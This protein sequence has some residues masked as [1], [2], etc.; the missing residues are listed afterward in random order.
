[1]GTGRDRMVRST[2]RGCK[3]GRDFP[4]ADPHMKAHAMT[5]DPGAPGVDI[6][7]ELS[8]T[9][10]PRIQVIRRIGAGGMG[11]VYLGRDPLLH[12]SVAVKVLGADLASDVV[13]HARFMREAE[14]V[15][16][17]NHPNV[18]SV[19]EVGELPSGT[20]YFVME[21]VDGIDMAEVLARDGVLSDA[22][23][24]R[25]IGEVASALAAAHARGLVHRDM[26]P[27]NLMVD[28]ETDRAVVLDFGISAILDRHTRTDHALTAQGTYIG[29]PKYTSPEQAAGE[30]LT[31]KS[32]VYSLGVTAFELLTGRPPFQDDHPM[33]LMA[34]HIK[35]MPP[36]LGSLRADLDPAFA[37]LI[38]RC[39]EKDP[40]AR[41]DAADIAAYLNP[42]TRT[43]LEWPPPGLESLRGQGARCLN[44]IALMQ[45]L[46][47]LFAL[48]LSTQPTQSAGGWYSYEQ[49]VLWSTV[50][51]GIEGGSPSSAASGA[52]T[53]GWV[54]VIVLLLGGALLVVPIALARG[55][56]T[57][58][59]LSDARHGGYPAALLYAVTLDSWGDTQALLNGTGAFA[60][61]D[62][63][64]RERIARDRRLR[65]LVLPSGLVCGVL[66][67]V[68][69]ALG[70]WR[71][72]GA[73]EAPIMSGIEAVLILLPAL[74]AL[75]VCDMLWMREVRTLGYRRSLAWRTPGSSGTP[76]ALTKAWMS[77]ARDV[78][79][80]ISAPNRLRLV[81]LLAFSLA[82]CLVALTIS[83]IAIRSDLFVLTV[84]RV[85]A[86]YGS[87]NLSAVSPANH[88]PGPARADSVLR[89]AVSRVRTGPPDDSLAMRILIAG[90]YARKLRG[91][92]RVRALD[93][94]FPNDAMLA[95]EAEAEIATRGVARMDSLPS[96]F[97]SRAIVRR[98]ASDPVLRLP[99]TATDVQ[100]LS[101]D[102]AT[103]WLAVFQRIARA[104]A[105]APPP[106]SYPGSLLAH[107]AR[108]RTLVDLWSVNDL[109]ML[110]S[111]ATY[112]ALS[113][114]RVAEA[115]ARARETI[116]VGF[117]FL[118]SPVGGEERLG[119]QAITAGA[120]D[121]MQVA[122]VSANTR[123]L[124]EATDI[125]AL[126]DASRQENQFQGGSLGLWALMSNPEDET[127]PGLVLLRDQHLRR[128]LRMILVN[129]AV[130]GFC[131]DPREVLFG[132]SRRRSAML[133]SAERLV[134]DIPR[135]AEWVSAQRAELAALIADPAAA[136]RERRAQ[137]YA[138]EGVSLPLSFGAMRARL[139]FCADD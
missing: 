137:V 70:L 138:R 56:R 75:V 102:T 134:A 86:K 10:A 103:R 40:R 81:P 53:V 17:V 23:A 48:A 131:L 84:V 136:I 9:L 88:A 28:A 14:A 99:L 108:G 58:A 115:E 109:V 60:T 65:L 90:L 63:R 126:A 100:T 114:G 110:Q 122:R 132:V 113:A 116:S 19:Y 119:V 20:P 107:F 5:G 130:S 11:A 112:L 77:T 66:L 52:A 127:P 124:S 105:M 93:P 83:V 7:E 13:A 43:L 72:R 71:A 33:A 78:L 125:A 26:K 31:G 82:L 129:A 128:S 1:M 85:A 120:A 68:C 111:A 22:R 24:K 12:R 39:L 118:R 6:P 96:N 4:F 46:L 74:I 64:I 57:F 79:P 61:L 101:R 59:T 15:A 51:N 133:D 45:A 76:S 41:P 27:A 16:T 95:A 89:A 47:L 106:Y 87:E 117:H 80:R 37:A 38:D 50:A 8:R 67:Y 92:E 94:L 69:W 36:K 35:E 62:P 97:G 98:L 123:L 121:L 54:I 44:A 104:P 30:T 25:I 32:D 18:V 2:A 29:T 21:L 73:S 3:I 49:S 42:G 34:A 139:Q 91:Y 135:S 55:A